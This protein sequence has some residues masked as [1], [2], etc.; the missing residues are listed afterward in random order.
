[1]FSGSDSRPDHI[2][3]SVAESKPPPDEEEEENGVEVDREQKVEEEE[4]QENYGAVDREQEGQEE[5]DEEG[6]VG[7]QVDVTSWQLPTQRP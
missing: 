3:D 2:W 1:M 6:E 5:A 4:E 7:Y